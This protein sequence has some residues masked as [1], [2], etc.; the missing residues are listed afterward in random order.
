MF[1]IFLLMGVLTWQ[2]AVVCFCSDAKTA[3]VVAGGHMCAISLFVRPGK[4]NHRVE[5]LFQEM[6]LDSRHLHGDGG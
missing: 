2:R 3:H 6:R 1:L 4:G 5:R